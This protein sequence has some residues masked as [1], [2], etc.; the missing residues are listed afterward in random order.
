M[1][2]ILA[3]AGDLCCAL[4]AIDA[5]ANAVYL[6]LPGFNARGRNSDFQLEDIGRLTEF[7]HRQNVKVYVAVN[8]LVL[9]HEMRDVLDL[10][11]QVRC[12]EVDAFILQDLGVLELFKTYFPDAVLHAS[13]QM[14]FHNS[15]GLQM[16]K[17]LGFSRVILERQVTFE[18]L[19]LMRE[20]V[21]IE[22][23]VFVYGALCVS[24]SGN[25]LMSSYQT[26]ASGNRGRC[27]QPCRRLFT[28]A[29]KKSGFFLSP[30]DLS[31]LSEIKKLE[32]IGI[33]SFKIEGRMRKAD[34]VSA[35]VN[36]VKYALNNDS[37][38]VKAYAQKTFAR[39]TSTGFFNQKKYTEIIQ[40]QTIASQG[41][42]VGKVISRE[43][44]KW[45]LNVEQTLQMGDRIRIQD[46]VNKG[47]NLT[48]LNFSQKAERLYLG[49]EGLLTLGASVYRI[50]ES[51]PSFER[52]ARL[53]PFWKRSLD[54]QVLISQKSCVV[55]CEN[56][57][58]SYE[59]ELELAQKQPLKVATVEEAFSIVPY[60]EFK[61]GKITVSLTDNFF[62]P[63]SV[64]KKLRQTFWHMVS[65]KLFPMLPNTSQRVI[66]QFDMDQAQNK[67][68]PQQSFNIMLNCENELFSEIHAE[69]KILPFF[70]P[71]TAIEEVKSRV[72]NVYESGV[73][74]FFVTRIEHLEL[75]HDLGLKDLTLYA[76]YPLAVCNRW[77]IELL[78]CLGVQFVCVHLELSK[79]DVEL[80][81]DVTSFPLFQHENGRLVVASS[82]AE[83]PVI[84]AISDGVETYEVLSPDRWG[85]THLLSKE[86][87]EMV[88]V[89][90][91][92]F[93]VDLRFGR[94]QGRSE[95]NSSRIWQ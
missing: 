2:E 6:G 72:K 45:I 89:E 14:G 65:E 52:Q 33:D 68:P 13:T 79:N 18:E 48:L 61:A 43:G 92:G 95:F 88:L 16:A 90:G 55:T 32:S 36:A 44:G 40:D 27:K 77:A 62:M 25:C 15:L 60:E 46:G 51:A 9:Q 76:L 58:F 20:K 47:V 24:L 70:I 22:L 11:A 82:R 85:V 23:E 81:R 41:E 10:I 80:L 5:G 91:C 53:L 50:G 86:S 7:A 8:T 38:L 37:D 57:P 30:S 56:Q 42:Y 67:V 4:A 71:E 84:G 35:A 49:F 73:K 31:L 12:Y 74:T 1:A 83:I 34:Y 21:D 17:N 87:C 94:G 29:Q 26:G 59:L 66:Q 64:L 78:A 39:R 63:S 19:K 75:F 93:C 69:S 54:I 3:P 28:T